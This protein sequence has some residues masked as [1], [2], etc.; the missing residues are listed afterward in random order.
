MKPGS[1]MEQLDVLED[2]RPCSFSVD[3]GTA[4]VDFE[5]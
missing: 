1:V 5:L 4:I 3:K 2:G